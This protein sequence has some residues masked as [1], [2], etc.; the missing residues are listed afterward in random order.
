[1]DTNH[2][3]LY[4]GAAHMGIEWIIQNTES[5]GRLRRAS[6][7]QAYYKT[8][9]SLA[10][11]GREEE[12]NHVINWITRNYARDDGYYQ[13]A[14]A[15]QTP[16]RADLYETLWIAWGAAVLERSD[17][18]NGALAF[19]LRH[20]DPADGGLYSSA[21]GNARAQGKDLRS[22]ALGGLVSTVMGR[23]DAA[24]AAAAFVMSLL[25]LQPRLESGHFFLVRDYSGRIITSFPS[26]SERYFV[27]TPRQ[28]R[29]LY[30][31]L[32]LAVAFLAKLAL[33]TGNPQY[34][35]AAQAYVDVCAS[36]GQSLLLHDYAG[37]LAWGLA[38]IYR[39]TGQALSESW[40]IEICDYLCTLQQPSG[41]WHLTFLPRTE[42]TRS[43]IQ[44]MS[45]DRT[46]E[47]SLWL[48]YVTRESRQGQAR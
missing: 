40:L 20:L 14:A 16:R 10:E 22:T 43:G 30:Y 45:Y 33:V 35:D 11:A 6:S 31:A 28:P 29:P 41:E 42:I 9:L 7:L 18:A 27:I 44:N 8:P 13:D 19:A 5:N 3:L 1:M 39:Q 46:A 34:L 15:A 25:R 21:A 17:I 36:Y 2:E 4:R 38:L 48:N 26:D 47:Y 24:A 32:G 23:M 12:A 37:K